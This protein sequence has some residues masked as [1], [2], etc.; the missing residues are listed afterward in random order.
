[1]KLPTT[2]MVEDAAKAERQFSQQELEEFARE[3]RKTAEGQNF[4]ARLNKARAIILRE[5]P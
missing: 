1:M 2:K 4:L 5:K 3:W